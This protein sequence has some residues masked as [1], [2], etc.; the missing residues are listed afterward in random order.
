M[1]PRLDDHQESYAN[2]PPLCIHV[3][4]A[5]GVPGSDE[6]LLETLAGLIN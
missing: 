1:P 4:R 2:P 5:D 6:T 3:Y